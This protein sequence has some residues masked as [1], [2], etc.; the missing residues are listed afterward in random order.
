MVGGG[1]A[2]LAA[3]H[4]LAGRPGVAVTLYEAGERLGG[5]VR[6][7]AFA[8]T[9]LDLGPDAFLA[10]RPEALALCREVG[11]EDGLVAPAT[12]SASVWVGG[13]LRRLPAGTVL[14]VPTRLGPL[15]RAGVLSPVGL[16]RA[17]LEPL[18]PGQPLVGDAALGTVVRRRL[19]AE[20]HRRLVDPL[21]GGINAGTTDR[22]SIEVCA[23]QLAAAAR[24]S[25]SLVRGARTVTAGTGGGA[26]AGPV[27]LTVPGGLGRLVDAL[28]RRLD[29][30]GAEVR[31]GEA[32]RA[33]HSSG[34]GTYVVGTASG[35]VV[36]DAVVVALP[37]P[38]AGRLVAPHA[39]GAGATLAAIEHASVTLVALA[40]PSAAV[41]RALDGS[42]F[43][44]AAGQGRL[45]TACSWASSKWAHLARPGQV[46]LRVSAG[47]AGDERASALDDDAVLSRLRLELGAALGITA[48]PSEVRVARWPDAFPQYAPGHLTRVA[49]AEEEL[50]ARLPGVTLAG[51][52]LA[53]IGLPACIASGRVAARRAI[54]AAS[55]PS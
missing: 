48:P 5:K 36:A 18:L 40:Y 6:T 53:G 41:P 39:P 16:A 55:R 26:G 33:L 42:G 22:L 1:I 2:G 3:A 34:H 43:V 23:P 9:D 47:R 51:A 8:G 13:R 11:L 29:A 17:A 32:V 54:E 38:A 27:F 20:V 24:H 37:A 12:T 21:V 44:V 10:R 25:A 35:P 31:T 7:E 14:G 46:L 45:M 49:A 28:A 50:A 30:A 15:A 4:E 19:G 52:A